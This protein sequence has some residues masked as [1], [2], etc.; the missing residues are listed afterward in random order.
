MPG[1]SLDGLEQVVAIADRFEA[2]WRQG[3]RP[4]IEDVLDAAPAALRAELL[5]DLLSIEPGRPFPEPAPGVPHLVLPFVIH[6][7]LHGESY[8]VELA[9][10]AAV[11][12]WWRLNAAY[13]Y[14]DIRLRHDPDSADR[15]S[16]AAAGASPHNQL[17][18][19]SL[20]NLPAHFEL[21]T[22][23]RY[24]DN[25]P[26]QQVGSYVDADVRVARRFGR[27]LEL[28]VVGQN[29]A[30]DHHR[31]FAGGTEVQ[32]GVYGAFRWWW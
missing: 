8:G 7:R 4:R 20:M 6:N 18:A 12:D 16:D 31:E 19:R 2:A 11:T 3:L 22:V 27:S 25:L 17:T 23:V 28:S 26:T 24:V 9:A 10:D 1:D 14:L 15:F 32:R 30:H 5:H 21:D 29:L 13:T